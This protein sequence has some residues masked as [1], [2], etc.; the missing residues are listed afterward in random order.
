MAVLLA[1]AMLCGIAAMQARAAKIP[2]AEQYWLWPTL[3]TAG[4][5]RGYSSGHQGIDFNKG[6]STTNDIPIYASK[7]GVVHVVYSGCKN[8]GAITNKKSCSE[9]GTGCAAK[10]LWKSSYGVTTCNWGFG[11]GVIIRH[12]DA[13]G[14]TVGYSDYA[15]MSKVTVKKG[16]IVYQGQEIGKMGNSGNSDGKHL[17]FATKKQDSL[18]N[19]YYDETK[20][21][22]KKKDMPKAVTTTT[23]TKPAT[24]T[25]KPITPIITNKAVSNL[26]STSVRLNATVSP[27]SMLQEHGYYLSAAAIPAIGYSGLLQKRYVDPEKNVKSGI[28]YFDISKLTPGVKYNYQFFIKVNGKE[29]LGPTGSFT[30]K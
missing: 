26:T 23:T 11:N 24:T 12:V 29:I 7:S 27:S 13:N 21:I 30:T 25:T 10:N 16:D 14:K 6:T 9:K 4:K 3:D 17:H 19:G 15:H 22:K 20:S 1:V 8:V 18:T 5:T 28:L 2:V